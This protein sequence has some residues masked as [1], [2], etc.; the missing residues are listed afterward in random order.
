MGETFAEYSRRDEVG[1][2]VACALTER[3]VAMTTAERYV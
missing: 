3:S 1:C 2:E